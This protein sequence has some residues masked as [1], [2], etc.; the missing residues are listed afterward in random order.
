MS[1]ATGRDLPPITDAEEAEIQAGIADDLDNPEWTEA[2][3]RAAVPFRQAF[4]DLYAG[5]ARDRASVE[6]GTALGVSLTLD[7]AVVERFMAT[8]PGWEGRMS[9]ALRRASERLP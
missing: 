5:W 2:D 8:G 7:R 1:S 3:F 6:A 4:P 9:E